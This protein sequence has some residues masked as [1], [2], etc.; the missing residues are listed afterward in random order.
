M[1]STVVLEELISSFLERSD[2]LMQL[3]HFINSE[4]NILGEFIG[5]K[6]NS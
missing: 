1:L 2:N 6:V 3:A 4:L 5:K